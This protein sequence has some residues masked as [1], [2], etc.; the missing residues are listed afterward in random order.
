LQGISV[1]TV[2]P[3]LTSRKIIVTEWVEGEKVRGP[4]QHPAAHAH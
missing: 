2:Y 1:A 4:R 3:Q